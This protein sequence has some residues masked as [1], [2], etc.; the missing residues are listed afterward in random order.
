[1]I[2]TSRLTRQ[3]G[4]SVFYLNTITC[5]IV[6]PLFKTGLAALVPTRLI[7]SDQQ[8]FRHH[9][10]ESLTTSNTHAYAGV[11]RKKT[12]K[13][14]PHWSQEQNHIHIRAP[15]TVIVM[16]TISTTSWV[17]SQLARG[18]THR[19]LSN[20]AIFFQKPQELIW[21]PERRRLIIHT[22]SLRIMMLRF[23]LRMPL[24]YVILRAQP[25]P[26]LWI[27][28]MASAYIKLYPTTRL[29]VL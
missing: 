1:M 14:Q 3:A 7:A 6:L 27:T 23:W 24:R 22:T 8:H 20:A 29:S 12:A 25:I 18:F 17:F 28:I 5:S 2:M 10:W 15:R 19:V 4:L 16:I 11:L 9:Q 21:L 26:A 13:S